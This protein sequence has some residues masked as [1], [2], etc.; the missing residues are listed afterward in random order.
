[1]GKLVEASEDEKE[2]YPK[3]YC[4]KCGRQLTLYKRQDGFDQETGKEHF[5]YR[6]VC[7]NYGVGCVFTSHD[8]VEHER[9]GNE[10]M[11]KTY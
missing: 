10:I 3:F 2:F 1:M 6:S 9:I 4:R 5:I 11:S 7:Q 8:Y